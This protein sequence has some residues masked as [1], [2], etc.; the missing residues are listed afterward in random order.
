VQS[1]G[2]R[3][4][5]AVVRVLIAALIVAAIVA[6]LIRSVGNWNKT[7]LSVGF[8]FTN[9]FSFFTIESN[10]FSVAVCLIGAILVFAKRSDPR[11][12]S[13]FR[14]V[15][16]TYMAV[17]GVVYN[18]LLRGVELPQGTTVIW[19]NEVLHVVACAYMVLD[20]LFAPGRPV[21]PWRTIRAIIVFPL[22][23]VVYTLIRA[24]LTTELN[25]GGKA[26]YP[27]PFLNPS[28]AHEGY[29]SVL[30]YV[31]LIAMVVCGAGAAA[32]WVSRRWKPVPEKDA[33]AA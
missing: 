1:P 25:Y 4:G 7:G 15:V 19:S 33:V 11:W 32:I 12:F 21:L 10:V 23:W 9:F 6:Q 2:Y 27:Y 16:V 28:L 14:V 17:T 29:W 3:Y 18:L 22:V 8:G 30:F 20:W 5:V 31:V 13:V 24:P 26:F